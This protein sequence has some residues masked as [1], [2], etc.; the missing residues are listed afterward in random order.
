MFV[1][2]ELGRAV[3]VRVGDVGGTVGLTTIPFPIGL[4]TATT[5]WTTTSP[6]VFGFVV[7]VCWTA[8]YC[9]PASAKTSKSVRT[10][11]PLRITLNTRCPAADQKGSTKYRV[12]L[13]LEPGVKP[14]IR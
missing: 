8:M 14:P 10:S 5:K 3:G 11:F 7:N 6:L 12:T 1:G 9:P 13:W 4:S 2:V